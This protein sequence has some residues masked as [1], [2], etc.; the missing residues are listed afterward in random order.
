MQNIYLLSGANVNLRAKNGLTA[1]DMAMLI[2]LNDTELFRML[3]DRSI[4]MDMQ[5]KKSSFNDLSTVS[6]GTQ[7]T[8]ILS[9]ITKSFRTLAK[10][11]KNM[12]TEDLSA[13]MIRKKISPN[14][15]QSLSQQIFSPLHQG[16]Y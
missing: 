12:S 1:F 4:E 6:K 2:N 16:Q 14:N 13:T 5:P 15:S 10:P 9:K 3:A 7:S 11:S 8:N